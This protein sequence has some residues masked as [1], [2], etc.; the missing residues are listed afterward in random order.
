M[1]YSSGSDTGGYSVSPAPWRQ[2]EAEGWWAGNQCYPRSSLHSNIAAT[3]P[4]KLPVGTCGVRSASRGLMVP[5]LMSGSLLSPWKAIKM[6]R[7]HPQAFTGRP[8]EALSA[9]ARP[10]KNSSYPTI[11]AELSL[12]HGPQWVSFW[13]HLIVG[14]F[15]WR[16]GC[17]CFL[18]RTHVGLFQGR[19]PL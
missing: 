13:H 16:V 8:A 6:R 15:F 11:A 10:L 7:H 17:N 19:P 1:W 9:Q 14:F 18:Q 5:I 2:C 3:S 12:H 4:C